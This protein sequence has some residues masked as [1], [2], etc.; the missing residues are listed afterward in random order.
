MVKV[1]GHV[2]SDMYHLSRTRTSIQFG[3]EKVIGQV[4]GSDLHEND[5]DDNPSLNQLIAFI[6]HACFPHHKPR[7][8]LILR[9][10]G[11]CV[12]CLQFFFWL[13]INLHI[14]VDRF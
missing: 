12:S 7:C 4:H 1:T 11:K 5:F 3:C 14:S 10:T 2:C 9:S 6:L 8:L 13:V